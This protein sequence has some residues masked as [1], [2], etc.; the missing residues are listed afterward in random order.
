[1]EAR[2]S[3]HSTNRDRRKPNH[4]AAATFLAIYTALY[5]VIAGL[6]HITTTPEATAAI[7]PEGATAPTAAMTMPAETIGTAGGLTA[8][9]PLDPEADE[10]DN[11]RECQLD[12]GVDSDCVFN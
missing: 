7:A 11:S 5:L 2:H 10:T 12:A 8:T 3:H 4:T 6:V 9:R 1:M